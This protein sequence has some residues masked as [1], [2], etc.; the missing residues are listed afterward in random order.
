MAKFYGA[1][2]YMETRETSPGIWTESIVEKNYCGDLVRNSRRYD[3]SE[4]LNDNLS[5]SNSISI[6]A[7]PYAVNNFHAMRY[8][9]FMN[10]AWKITDV[11]VQ[12]P[13]LVLT[14]GGLYNGEQADT[15]D[16]AGNASGE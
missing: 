4:Q 9:K 3:R 7:D 2:G 16:E 13:R 11:E 8:V 5:I 1:I 15:S 14:I 12:F 6:V 10:A